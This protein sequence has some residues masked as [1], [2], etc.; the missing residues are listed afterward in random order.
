M[1]TD[2]KFSSFPFN[3]GESIPAEY[4]CDGEDVS[5]PLEWSGVPEDT[6][7]FALIV[8]D[9]DA[10][11]RTF[12]HWVCFNIPGDRTRLVREV[13]A[14]VRD[15]WPDGKPVFVRIS[16]T[17]WLPDRES[18]DLDQSARLAPLLAEAGEVGEVARVGPPLDEL[19]GNP[20]EPHDDRR[21]EPERADM[22]ARRV[23][24]LV[25][26]RTTPR[27]DLGN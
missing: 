12:V 1:S 16:A 14:A 5:P 21:P 26:L 8:D 11:G 7:S 6:E 2:L 9:P 20:V 4:T 19:P 24:R 3:P 22:L 13:T 25:A 18:W 27:A 15:V 10:P 17:D 23:E